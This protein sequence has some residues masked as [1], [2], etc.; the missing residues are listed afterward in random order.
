MLSENIMIAFLTFNPLHFPEQLL[1][2]QDVFRPFTPT[3]SFTH[4]LPCCWEKL[5]IKTHAGLEAR[6]LYSS[7][8]WNIKEQPIGSVKIDLNCLCWEM[9]CEEKAKMTWGEVK[10]CFDCA[11]LQLSQSI[12]CLLPCRMWMTVNLQT[13]LALMFTIQY[14]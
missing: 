13:L 1:Q 12:Y 6:R 8:R 9:I 2:K 10:S 4:R 5:C 11:L 7:V 14:K 3:R